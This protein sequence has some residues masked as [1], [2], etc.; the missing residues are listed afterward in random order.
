MAVAEKPT[1]NARAHPYR[2]LSVQHVEE[3]PEPDFMVDYLMGREVYRRTDYLALIH[4]GSVGLAAVGRQENNDLFQRVV[5]VEV[6]S[7]P[8]H[9]MLIEDPAVD[10]GNATALA[11]AAARRGRPG[12]SGFVVKGM[13]EH[14]NFIWEPDPIR[15]RVTEVTPPEPPKLLRQ[16]QQVVDFDEDLPPV[17]L[18][19][20][21]VSFDDLAATVPAGSYL[22]PC[23][24]AGTELAGD[25]A[26]LD[27]RPA[28]RDDWV[29]IG[30]E[31]SMQFHRHFYGDEPRQVDICPRKRV[32]EMASDDRWLVKC[33]MLERGM[34]YADHRATVPWGANLDEV[35][36]AL[37]LLT[38]VD[39][40]ASLPG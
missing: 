1:K 38:G 6:W 36:Q 12:I 9:T 26:Y 20:D 16:A 39:A 34:E 40:V 10:V 3:V 8:S 37:R 27:T 14:I 28:T 15:I 29:M 24:G 32:E 7:G 19:I 33:C 21:S 25:M 2:G 31:R 22:L 17:E 35:R 30:C 13:F 5:D 4:N 18:V 23:R 11:R